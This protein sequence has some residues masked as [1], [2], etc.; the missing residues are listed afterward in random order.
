MSLCKEH[1]RHSRDLPDF[2][3][4]LR[5]FPLQRFG[6][7]QS[8]FEIALHLS[9]RGVGSRHFIFGVIKLT[10]QDLHARIDLVDLKNSGS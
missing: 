5:H 8:V 1:F 6:L 3:A 2:V 10:L 4:Q 9:L 7:L